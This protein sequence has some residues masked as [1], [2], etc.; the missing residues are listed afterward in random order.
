M[1]V[2][3]TTGIIKFSYTIQSLF[4]AVT[5][6]TLTQ[7][8]KLSQ[9]S[10]K[11]DEFGL[12]EDERLQFNAFLTEGHVKIFG[13]LLKMTSGVTTSVVLDLVGTTNPVV[14]PSVSVTIVDKQG[15][16]GNYLPMIDNE[17]KFALQNYI[18]KEWY[19]KCMLADL[20][21][22]FDAKYLENM[23][24]IQRYGLSLRKPNMTPTP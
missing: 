10:D 16:N 11:V 13:K 8:E 21:K 18:I 9:E 5:L 20:A 2:T 19:V 4:D 12:S 1:T 3:K 14:E 22:Y 7:A 15:Y 23:K 17:I 6:E 24:N